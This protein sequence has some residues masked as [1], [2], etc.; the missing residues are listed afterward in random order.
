MAPFSALSGKKREFLKISGKQ[1]RS[2]HSGRV[3]SSALDMFHFKES[4]FDFLMKKISKTIFVEK[5]NRF[6]EVPVVPFLFP[7]RAEM[8]PGGA[9]LKNVVHA[10]QF[11]SETIKSLFEDPQL[12]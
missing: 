12:F 7:E 4:T 10:M 8:A 1:A 6:L 5:I 3:R 11:S 9:N 2:Q